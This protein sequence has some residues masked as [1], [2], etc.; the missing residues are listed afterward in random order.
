MPVGVSCIIRPQCHQLPGKP[1]RKIEIPA[2][3][4]IMFRQPFGSLDMTCRGQIVP[5][6]YRQFPFPPP[7]AQARQFQQRV[8]A[9]VGAM[10]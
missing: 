1:Q 10:G 9:E 2:G 8:S 6:R 5:D 3:M 7:P 4:L